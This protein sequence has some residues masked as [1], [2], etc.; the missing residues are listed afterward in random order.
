MGLIV[1]ISS[2]SSSIFMS[3]EM[4]N[5]KVVQPGSSGYD[6]SHIGLIIPSGPS[7]SNLKVNSWDA[8]CTRSATTKT[9]LNPANSMRI[10]GMCERKQTHTNPLL[11]YVSFRPH[12]PLLRTV[13]NIADRLHIFCSEP[14]LI[15]PDGELVPTELELEIRNSIRIIIIVVGILN[16]FKEEMCLRVVQVSRQPLLESFEN[17]RI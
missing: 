11:A 1:F 12:L 10:I 14:L 8:T 15:A 16:K 2:R 17:G 7:R 5:R 9:A 6:G 4:S 3:W 13:T